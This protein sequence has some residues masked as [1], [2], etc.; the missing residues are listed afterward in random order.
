MENQRPLPMVTVCI[1]PALRKEAEQLVA[2]SPPVHPAWQKVKQRGR[3]FS[4]RTSS[5]ED[6]E[7]LADWA[8]SWLVEPAEPLGKMKRQAFQSVIKRT[9]RFVHL[10]LVGSCHFMA[11][12]WK[13]SSNHKQR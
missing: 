1:P 7:E 6:L 4:L 5:I 11:T 13:E 2:E 9:G 12:G 10:R 8:Y 3:H